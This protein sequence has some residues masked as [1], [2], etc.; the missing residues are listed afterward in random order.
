M[1]RVRCA[2]LHCSFSHSLRSTAL[3]VIIWCSENFSQ[4]PIVRHR[5]VGSRLSKILRRDWKIRRTNGTILRTKLID[6]SILYVMLAAISVTQF[7]MNCPTAPELSPISLNLKSSFLEC[8][9]ALAGSQS[10][11][12]HL[13]LR[14]YLA[15][16]LQI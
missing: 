8:C 7:V 16:E 2:F 12:L 10:A 15:Q 13:R 11:C 3:H 6:Y 14:L 1:A 5:R 9:S 4:S